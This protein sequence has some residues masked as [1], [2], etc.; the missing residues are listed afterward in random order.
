MNKIARVAID[1]TIGFITTVTVVA[2]LSS[3]TGCANF[4]ARI[5]DEQKRFNE[6]YYTGSDKI[7]PVERADFY[8][9]NFPETSDEDKIPMLVKDLCYDKANFEITKKK[10]IKEVTYVT[11]NGRDIFPR[12]NYPINWIESSTQV[13]RNGLLEKGNL[14]EMADERNTLEGHI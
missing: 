9:S 4:R 7:T 11:W 6:P 5:A 2:A 12:K 1:L 14:R 8:I 13:Y 10:Y 3:I